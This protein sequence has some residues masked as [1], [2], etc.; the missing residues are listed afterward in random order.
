MKFHCS[1]LK[2]RIKDTILDLSKCITIMFYILMFWVIVIVFLPIRIISF[3]VIRKLT[4]PL[5]N[6]QD[7]ATDYFMSKIFFMFYC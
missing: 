7:K 5:L 6:L 4:K 3:G 2:E 1:N